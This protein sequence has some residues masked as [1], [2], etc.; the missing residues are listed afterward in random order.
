MVDYKSQGSC[1]GDRKDKKN[2]RWTRVLTR[3]QVLIV[4]FNEHKLAVR[5]VLPVP[6]G[7]LRMHMLK[8]CPWQILPF[9]FHGGY[10]GDVLSSRLV[11]LNP[12]RY[13]RSTGFSSS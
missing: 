1:D 4:G 13:H 12:I 8:H 9:F 7:A 6:T 3:D 11:S 5:G 10:G 2:D